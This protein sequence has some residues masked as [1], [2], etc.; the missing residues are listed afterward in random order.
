V[1][2]PDPDTSKELSAGKM[3]KYFINKYFKDTLTLGI[4]TVH[5]EEIMSEKSQLKKRIPI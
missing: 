5:Y 4:G 3:L 2:S 1:P